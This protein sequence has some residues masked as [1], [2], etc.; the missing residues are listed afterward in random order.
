M[1]LTLT[2]YITKVR[3]YLRESSSSQSFWSDTFLK[4]IFNARYKKRCSELVMAFEG[5]FRHEATAPVVKGQR[6]YDWP[7]GFQRLHK[8]ELLS[9]SGTRYPIAR[10]ERHGTISSRVFGSVVPNYRP[11]DGGFILEPTP[12][13]GISAGRTVIESFDRDPNIYPGEYL[14]PPNSQVNLITDTN[15]IKEGAGCIV[16]STMPAATSPI[17][18]KSFA[19]PILFDPSTILNT[20]VFL[21]YILPTPSAINVTMRLLVG[22]VI[23]Q[24]PFLGSQLHLGWNNLS[25]AIANTDSFSSP[26]AGA[27]TGIEL[28]WHPQDRTGLCWDAVYVFD[29]DATDM[30][31]VLEYAGVPADLGDSDSLSEEFPKIYEELLV[32]DTAIAAMAAEGMLEGGQVRA[33]LRERTEFEQGFEQFVNQRMVSRQRIEPFAPHYQ[34]A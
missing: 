16:L 29:F 25:F 28:K 2:Q 8:M 19:F 10:W 21:P 22:G 20:W 5:F 3:Q 15:T 1:A 18:A 26:P 27:V 34:D 23:S 6:F 24:Y 12:D 4:N 33:L 17:I 9:P 14:L 13:F 30:Q 11:V 7:D 31:L 32:L